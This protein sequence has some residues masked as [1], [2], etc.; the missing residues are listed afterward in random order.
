MIKGGQRTVD[1]KALRRP[2]ASCSDACGSAISVEEEEE[3]CVTAFT[4][5]W[6]ADRT[7]ANWELDHPPNCFVFHWCGLGR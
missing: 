5:I 3:A 7:E 1:D 6:Q 4:S 2:S